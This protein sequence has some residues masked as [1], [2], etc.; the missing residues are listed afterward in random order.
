MKQILFIVSFSEEDLQPGDEPGLECSKIYQG[1]AAVRVIG[2]VCWA[3]AE[4]A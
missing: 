4:P 3:M 1:F 2:I